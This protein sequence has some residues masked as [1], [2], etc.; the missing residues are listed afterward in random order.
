MVHEARFVCLSCKLLLLAIYNL[1]ACYVGCL[2]CLAH[3]VAHAQTGTL[4][5]IL[6]MLRQYGYALPCV[7]HCCAQVNRTLAAKLMAQQELAAQQQQGECEAEGPP[8][9]KRKGDGL[10]NALADDRFKAL[11][12]DEAFA[13]DED[14]AEYRLLH[15]NVQPGGRKGSGGGGSDD[16]E[17]DEQERLLAEHF[18]AMSDDDDD[19]DGD[20]DDSDDDAAAGSGSDGGS[21]E[22]A[23]RQQQRRQGHWQQLKRQQPD[24]GQPRTQKWQQQQEQ[25]QGRPA[26]KR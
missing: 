16:D 26:G 18:Q 2:W 21:E 7:P 4:L 5:S 19:D 24:T 1:F 12:V 11:F 6:H 22:E 13:V 17:P 15:P 25:Q 8:A 9:K 3:R 10:P 14:S 23:D 20:A